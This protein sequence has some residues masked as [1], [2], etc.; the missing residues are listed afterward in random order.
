ME[1]EQATHKAAARIWFNLLTE[2]WPPENTE[3]YWQ[4]VTDRMSQVWNENPDN[5]LLRGLLLM[6]H[7]YLGDIANGKRTY[8]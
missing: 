3:K 8:D 5:E 6:T 1:R 2:C 7:Q 4:R